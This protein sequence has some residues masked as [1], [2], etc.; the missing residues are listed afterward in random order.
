MVEQ[1]QQVDEE[2]GVDGHG[3]FELYL[4]VKVRT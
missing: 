4:K 3:E 1:G 2:E